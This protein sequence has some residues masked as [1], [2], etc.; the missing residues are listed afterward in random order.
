MT[1]H[2]I[3]RHFWALLAE[4]RIAEACET[5]WAEDV[6][7]LEDMPG[8]M[9]RLQGA[10]AIAEKAAWWV[11]N[12]E[13]H[14][15]RVERPWVHGDQFIVRCTFE[16]TPKGGNRTMMDEIGLYTVAA[17]EIAEERFFYALPA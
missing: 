3:T 8:P 11:S 1:N 7:A 4:G 10:A 6:V 9:A 15:T 5:Y 16:V 12:H 14:S 13:V 2:D 17:G